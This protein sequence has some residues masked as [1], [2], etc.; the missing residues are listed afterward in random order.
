MDWQFHLMVQIGDYESQSNDG[1]P[2]AGTGLLVPR[3]AAVSLLYGSGAQAI[4]GTPPSALPN[5]RPRLNQIV[6]KP[7]IM[8]VFGDL[9]RSEK[10]SLR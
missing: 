6:P 9:Y 7:R 2:M 4:A 5:R 1:W 8:V 10:L 3:I